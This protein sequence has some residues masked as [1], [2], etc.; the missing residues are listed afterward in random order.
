MKPPP[1]PNGLERNCRAKPNGI[2][3][4]AGRAMARSGPI[5]GERNRL[6]RAMAILDLRRWD[7]TPVG[8]FPDG[9]SD[10]GVADL[11][12]NGWEW[13]RTPFAPFPG[14]QPF[15]FIPVTP[16]IFSTPN[17]RH[18]RRFASHGRV[19]AAAVV[20]QFGSSHIIHTFTRLSLRRTLRFERSESN[21]EKLWPPQS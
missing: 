3:P 7:P 15:S 2:A 4:L 14:F 18:E 13:T 11:T 12:G 21:K 16:L 10:F 8:S 20:S 19:H 17:T 9:F 5:P 6:L 1:T